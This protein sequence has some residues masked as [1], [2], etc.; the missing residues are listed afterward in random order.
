MD[1]DL[2][3]KLEQQIEQEAKE[4]ADVPK[5]PLTQFFQGQVQRCGMCG[6]L[7]PASELQ[8]MANAHGRKACEECRRN[9]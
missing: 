2:K 5:I 9:G 7:K 1:A 8:E 4:L 3:T 6:Q